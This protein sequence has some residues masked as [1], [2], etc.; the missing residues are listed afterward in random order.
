MNLFA[1]EAGGAGNK[2]K[3]MGEMNQ[4]GQQDG[5]FSMKRPYV[6]SWHESYIRKVRTASLDEAVEVAQLAGVEWQETIGPK[7][8]WRFSI[9][10][11][12]YMVADAIVGGHPGDVIVAYD[13]EQKRIVGMFLTWVSRMTTDLSMQV[14][15]EK[16]IYV[17]PEYR[18]QGLGVK[19]IRFAEKMA[20]SKGSKRLD[21]SALVLADNYEKLCEKYKRMGYVPAHTTFVKH[22][23]HSVMEEEENN[24]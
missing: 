7:L 19:L 6:P 9:G 18:G 13:D 5:S 10:S 24:G 14:T 2:N 3:S 11:C 4:M 20:F 1:S 12:A 22:L 15:S 23:D 8:G 21:V 16:S 17:L